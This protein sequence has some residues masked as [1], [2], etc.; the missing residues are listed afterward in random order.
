L[1]RDGTDYRI[2]EMGVEALRESS[3][4]YLIGLLEDSY[5]LTLHAKRVTLMPSD[6]RLALNLRQDSL[7][8]L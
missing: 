3:E 8:P 2:T 7:E 1:T 6:L 4:A 5:M